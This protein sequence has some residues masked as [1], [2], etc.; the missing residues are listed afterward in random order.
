MTDDPKPARDFLPL[1]YA[2]PNPWD[3]AR[4]MLS[5]QRHLA[6]E[7]LAARDQGTGL[8]VDWDCVYIAELRALGLVEGRH[9][10]PQNPDP[11]QGWHLTGFA[12]VVRR[13]LAWIIRNQPP[14]D[15][16]GSEAA[17]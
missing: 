14:A 7:L 4:A 6:R 15:W 5:V 2:L 12:A 8:R 11:A 13:R 16:H 9:D 17:E 10:R 3:Y 1:A